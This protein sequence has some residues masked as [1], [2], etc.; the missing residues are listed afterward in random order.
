MK[1]T[2]KLLAILIM[3]T[4]MNSCKKTKNDEAKAKFSVKEKSTASKLEAKTP[5]IGTF[6]FTKAIIGVSKVDFEIETGSDDQDFE[7][8]G[9]YSFDVLTGQST[10][11]MP[12]V[13]I[14]PGTYHELEVE[15]DNV[16]P[17]GNSIEISGTY[18]IGNIDFPF[19]FT[20]TMDEDYDVDNPSGIQVNEGEV[21]TFLL[22]L[23]LPSLFAG[24][25][26]STAS[27]DNDG[28]IRINATSNSNLQ[29]IIENNFDDIMDFDED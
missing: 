24:I 21:V 11:P 14:T 9:A 16:L 28:V 17:S 7:Y 8:E 15:I 3:L 13:E 2:I 10:P 6:N 29:D 1:T 22:E 12:T 26:F 20:S 18:S 19:E 4:A 23:D 5:L 25:D 27:I